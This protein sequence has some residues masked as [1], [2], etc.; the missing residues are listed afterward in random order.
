MGV[1]PVYL[2]DVEPVVPLVGIV[3]EEIALTSPCE[4]YLALALVV[5]V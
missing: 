1:V 2:L 4:V 5:M 3:Y